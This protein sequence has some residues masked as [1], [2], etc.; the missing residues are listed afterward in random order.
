MT[1]P[2]STR[3]TPR[4][5]NARTSR[6]VA[7]IVASTGFTTAVVHAYLDRCN[8]VAEQAVAAGCD[9]ETALEFVDRFVDRIPPPGPSTTARPTRNSTMSAA[10][11]MH[12]RNEIGRPWGS[13]YGPAWRPQ[14]QPGNGLL[15]FHRPPARR[16]APAPRATQP[17]QLPVEELIAVSRASVLRAQQLGPL[18]TRR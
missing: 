18:P 3:G 4:P 6:A 2:T 10:L 16:G 17:R 1:T 11:P 15:V 9:L 7:D 12:L 8:S 5:R 13:A 14:H